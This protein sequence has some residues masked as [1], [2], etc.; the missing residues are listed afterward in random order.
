MTKKTKSMA[1]TALVLTILTLC[2]KALGFVKQAVVAYYFGA[3]F[4]TD[5][6]YVAFNFVG[7]LSSAFIRAITISLVGIY[8]HCLV[9]RGKDAASKLLSACLEVLVPVVLVV[10]LIAYMITPQ[11]AGALAPKYSPEESM[12]LQSYLRICYPFFLFAVVTLVWTSLLDANKDFVASRTESFITSTTTIL[13][14]VCLY[15]IQAVTSLVIAQYISYIIFGTL[16]L[17]RGRKYFDFA[18]VNFKDVPEIRTV[19]MTALPLFIGNSVSQINKLVDNSLS[20]GLG[21]G[22]VSALSYAVVLEDFVSI[23]LVNNVVDILYV[24]FSA[25]TAEGDYEKL[26]DTMKKAINIMICIMIPITIVT[27]LCSKE[28]VSIAYYRGSFTWNDVLLTSAALIG[29]A[30]GFTSMGVRDIIL[31]G[32]YSFKNTKGPMITGFF[33]V[34]FN[35]IFSI[36]LSRFIGIMGISIASSISLTVN[37]LINSQM[38]KKHIPNYKFSVHVPVLLKQLPG[39]A[40]AVAVVL[41]V[42]HF[43]SSNLLTFMIAAVLAL[44]GYGV[45]LLLMRIE[46][47]E[48]MKA[49]ILAKIKR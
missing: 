44:G 22:N 26:T 40:Y 1:S 47:V 37:F 45:I 33:A 10:L 21:H 25:Y 12:L 41:V 19:L 4:E 31:R 42:K 7:S 30:V 13:C 28:I 2:F 27:C 5:I 24:N 43:V 17:V 46:E 11:I 20:T 3:T 48:F 49:K 15:S 14:C 6:Y 36:L 34:G 23:I 38:L 16:L 39:A 8:T 35:I 18:F 9:Q 32:L 29:Y